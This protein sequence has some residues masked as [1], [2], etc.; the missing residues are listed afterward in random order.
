MSG[1][2][3]YTEICPFRDSYTEHTPPGLIYLKL[4]R[5]IRSLGGQA[6][7]LANNETADRLLTDDPGWALYLIRCTHVEETAL[8][9]LYR[10]WDEAGIVQWVALAKGEGPAASLVLRVLRRVRTLVGFSAVASWGDNG[11]VKAF[12]REVGIESLHLELGP[13][14]APFPETIYFD[15]EGTN[16]LAGLRRLPDAPDPW[17]DP[18]FWLASWFKEHN[19]DKDPAPVDAA[20]SW[21]RVPPALAGVWDRRLCYIPLQLADD[22][23]LQL[24]SEYRSPREFLAAVVPAVT[25]LGY[26]AVVKPHPMA[27]TRPYNLVA[28]AEALA[29]LRALGGDACIALAHDDAAGGAWLLSN[30]ALVVTINSSVGFEAGLFGTP[31]VLAGEAAYDFSSLP[32]F[33]AASLGRVVEGYDRSRMDRAVSRMLGEFLYPAGLATTRT[34]ARALLLALEEAGGTPLDEALRRHLGPAGDY[35]A[36][37][38]LTL[39][40]PTPQRE[41]D[42]LDQFVGLPAR[43]DGDKVRLGDLTLNYGEQAFSGRARTAPAP[44][45]AA[46]TSGPG[47]PPASAT[48]R[49]WG[50]AHRRG[51]RTPVA[52]VL[53]VLDD[54][55]LGAHPASLSRL[56]LER[57]ALASVHVGFDFRLSLPAGRDLDE[58]R[59][60]PFDATGTVGLWSLAGGATGDEIV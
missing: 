12:C 28:Q 45:P 13:T 58:V 56:D 47:H 27:H 21:K 50:Y 60:M 10:P 59:L 2:L 20:M 19:S 55:V 31:V 32:R 53:S 24:G 51:D 36:D 14:R 38:T 4:A 37:R 49:F 11:A 57:K 42:G 40:D 35:N 39:S 22:L 43:L 6:W 23:N 18:S 17:P 26:L 41:Q 8:R 30:A 54:R 52:G 33:E 1:V 48:Y 5:S 3:F 44:A 15:G 34:F 46:D 7:V 9:D 16:V 29:D 25:A